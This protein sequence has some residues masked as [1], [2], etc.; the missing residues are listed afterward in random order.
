MLWQ[1]RDVA[2]DPDTVAPVLTGGEVGDSHAFTRTIAVTISDYGVYDTGVNTSPVP[3]VGPTLYA[4][5]THE[6]GTTT[7]A[8]PAA[9]TPYNGDQNSCVDNECIWSAD[10]DGLARGDSVTYYITASDMYPPGANSVQS[11]DYTFEVGN[12]TN[13]LVIEWHEYSDSS[14]TYYL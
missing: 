3:G 11:N 2:A 8:T 4:T 5:I 14:S 13:T 7:T 6:D 10:I 12:P 1:Y 9:L